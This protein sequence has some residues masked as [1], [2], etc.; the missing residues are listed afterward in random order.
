ME[1][2][3]NE[4]TFPI[5]HQIILHNHFQCCSKTEITYLPFI[6]L[7]NYKIH[8]MHGIIAET[9][10][11]IFPLEFLVSVKF[12]IH[13]WPLRTVCWVN[14]LYRWPH[15]IKQFKF[16]VFHIH[17][18]SAANCVCSLIYILMYFTKLN[19]FARRYCE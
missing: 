13:F 18:A 2:I 5:E 8:I 4:V 9:L 3:A 1:H 16:L 14:E 17:S 11:I 19:I 10:F 7:S 12:L 15:F 6:C